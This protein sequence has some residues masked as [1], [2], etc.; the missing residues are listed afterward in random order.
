[1]RFPNKENTLEIRF[2]V[3]IVDGATLYRVDSGRGAPDLALPLLF[4]DN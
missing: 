2:T 4:H 3:Y 1:M